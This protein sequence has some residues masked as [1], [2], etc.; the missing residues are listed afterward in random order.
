[1]CTSSIFTA[2]IF[3]NPLLFLF[4]KHWCAFR[5]TL[6]ELSL[7][8][9]FRTVVNIYDGDLVTMYWLGVLHILLCPSSNCVIQSLCKHFICPVTTSFSSWTIE[10]KYWFR[11]SPLKPFLSWCKSQVPYYM[12][13]IEK[14]LRGA[15]TGEVRICYI[16]TSNCI[17]LYVSIIV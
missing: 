9:C 17:M 1:M 14:R 5:E 10:N 4:Q 12:C 13:H 11:F 6:W 2:S 7:K 16:T 15:L 3:F 8:I